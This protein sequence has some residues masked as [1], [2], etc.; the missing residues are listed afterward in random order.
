MSHP[1]TLN[2]NQ[3]RALV[4]D[5]DGVLWQDKEALPGLLEFFDLLRQRAIRFVL[6]TNNATKT[7]DQFVQKLAGFG[8][9]IGPENVLTSSLATAAYL[10]RE[11]QP[12][13][14]IFVV[15]QEGLRQAMR[16]AGFE[17]MDNAD[18][19]VDIVVAGA[20]FTLTYEKVKYATFLIRRGARFI[21]TNGDLTFPTPDGLAPGAG[22]ILALLEA[23]TGVK[24][25]T[26][27]KPARLMY[28]I[29]LETM[30]VTPAET[31]M[32]GDRLDTDIVG[33]QQAGLKTIMVLTGVDTE[34]TCREK[35]IWPD[36][37]F[38]GIDQLA[39]VWRA[40]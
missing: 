30:G 32:L 16:D 39:E 21:G 7:P 38:T 22:S 40:A 3:I 4:I 26:I 25:P 8:V 29:A 27:G 6:A 23:A 5:G 33:G 24:P 18:Q 17:I 34:E 28:D 36:A 11:Y 12:G 13:T 20:D 1:N 9:T 37:I 15:G 31:A 2:L 14:K 35:N 10:R 19:D